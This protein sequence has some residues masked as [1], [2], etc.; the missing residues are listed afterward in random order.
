[1]FNILFFLSE[2]FQYLQK[3]Q[4][5][6]NEYLVYINFINTSFCDFITLIISEITH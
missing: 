3:I 6:V 2:Q 1:M 4:F 5:I